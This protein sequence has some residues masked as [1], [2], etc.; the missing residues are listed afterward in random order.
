MAARAFDLN[1]YTNLLTEVHPT[2]P[3]T[4]SENQRLIGI[5]NGLTRI[6]FRSKRK[7]CWNSCWFYLG[8]SK[9]STTR[10]TDGPQRGA[11]GNDASARSQAKDL[12]EIFG[13]KGTT[14]EV[15]RGNGRSAN[16]RLRR[17]LPG[18]GFPS[19]CSCDGRA[20]GFS[21]AYDSA[22]AGCRQKSY[23][24]NPTRRTRSRNRGSLRIGSR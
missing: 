13:S 5:V 10:P 15:L 17:W 19:T 12:Y 3:Q 21:V 20:T 22:E 16:R 24:N 11:P 14:S 8:N 6:D 2:V 23:S 4:E 1:S 9:T 7:S 18:S